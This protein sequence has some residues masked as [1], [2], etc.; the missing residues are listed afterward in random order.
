MNYF[1]IKKLQKK[2]G[3][4]KV[5]Y[6][7]DNGQGFMHNDEF[8][9][10][11]WSMIYSGACMLPTVVHKDYT[12]RLIAARQMLPVGSIGSFQRSQNYW[13]NFVC[14]LNSVK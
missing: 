10:L 8:G 4:A 1:Q 13:E 11:V 9:E 7:I 3:I 14:K 2:Y 12:G 5:Q 6:L